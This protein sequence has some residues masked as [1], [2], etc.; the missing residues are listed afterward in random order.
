M[1]SWQP[2]Y[3]SRMEGM[4]TSEIREILKLLDRPNI[5]SFAGGIPDPA[6][7]PAQEIAAACQKLL[8]DSKKAATA[9]QYSV[10]EGYLPLRQWLVEQLTS[11]GVVG[12][13]ADNILITNGSQQALDF[14]GKML[15]D[16][17]DTVLVESPTYLGAMQAFNAYQPA[18]ADLQD[19]F[20]SPA[21]KGGGGASFAPKFAPK[22]AYVMPEFQNPSGTSLSLAA[23]HALLDAA[24][25]RNIPL[26]E[27]NAYERLRYDGGVVPPLLALASQRCGGVDQAPVLYCGTFSKSIAPALR[28]GWMVAG[29]SI[30]KK[31][32]LLKQGS[33]LNVSSF[34]QMLAYEIATTIFESH[35]AKISAVYKERRDAMLAALATHMPESVRW[36]KPE[37]GMFIWLTLPAHYDSAALLKQAIAEENIAFVPGA[38]FFADRS[39]KN[40]LRLNFSLSPPARI[41]EG[42][43]RLARLLHRTHNSLL[44][45]SALRVG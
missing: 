21:D 13:T 9:L 42:I 29:Q 17:G 39:G 40:T 35:T 32:V 28:I 4:Q 10:S 1:E 14:I 27:D 5:I 22:F 3:A 15:I 44:H 12:C 45:D 41:E 7:F 31:A 25:A 23:R 6:F 37:G 18:Y 8:L 19:L 11:Q 43:S 2:H 16:P 26:V 24:L 38:A 33:D 20:H 36:T 34:T 30:I